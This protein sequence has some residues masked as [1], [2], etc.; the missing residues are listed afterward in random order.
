MRFIELSRHA[1]MLIPS[2]KERVRRF[3]DALHH[4][5]RLAMA[6]EI[7]TKTSF[8]QA[9]EIAHP[10]ESIC[11]ETTK[12][13][14]D[15]VDFDVILGM[16]W[17]SQYHAIL[18]C[19]ANT[20]QWIVKKGCLAYLPFVIDV[21][22]RTPTVESVPVVREFL[23]VLMSDLPGIPP[24]SDIDFGIDLAPVTQPIS[25]LLYPMDLVELKELKEQLQE[26]LDKGFIR[27]N[28]SHWGASV[29]FV[30]KNDGSM[31]M[32]IDYR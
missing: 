29:M 14:Q 2:K 22:D 6:R 10:I 27:H 21:S 31:R 28:M 18:D 16:E 3:I 13:M 23:D 26:L 9:V 32:C 30:K 12:M 7:E 24:D 5:I 4:S 25:I 20:A 17:L 1:N 8:H 15:M 19:H 11:I